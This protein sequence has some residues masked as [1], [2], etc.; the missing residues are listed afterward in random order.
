MP[1]PRASAP[2]GAPAASSCV[3]ATAGYSS[4]AVSHDDPQLEIRR[5]RW[6]AQVIVIGILGLW[7][8][9]A[10]GGIIRRDKPLCQ[11]NLRPWSEHHSRFA[12]KAQRYLPLVEPLRGQQVVGFI[13]SFHHEE[14][15]RMMAQS[16]L[17]PTLVIDSDQPAILIA[18]FKDDEELGRFIPASPFIIRQRFGQGVAIVERP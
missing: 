14:G 12:R 18:S 16:M 13:S 1:V 15:Q 8:L 11:L 7:A 2:A 3:C 6:L 10:V 9:G 5:W 4:P 17:A